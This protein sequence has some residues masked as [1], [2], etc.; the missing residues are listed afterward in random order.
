MTPGATAGLSSSAGLV[1]VDKSGETAV[2]REPAPGPRRTGLEPRPP[3][4]V[5]NADTR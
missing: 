4:A 5:A 2:A 1:H 3:P